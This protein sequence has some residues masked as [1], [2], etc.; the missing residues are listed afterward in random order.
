MGGHRRWPRVRA[1]AAL[2][3]TRTRPPMRVACHAGQL[4]QPV[5]GRHRPLRARPARPAR[6]EPASSRSRSRPA[7]RPRNVP[8]AVPWIDLGSPAR[9]RPLRAVAPAPAPGRAARR[10]RRARAEPG[11]PARTR[12]A[13]RGHGARHRVPPR[14]RGHD[15]PRRGVPPARPRARAPRSRPRARAVGVHARRADPRR[16]RARR[17]R[18][19]AARRRTAP[20]RA[21]RD[22]IDAT[23]ARCGVA[24]A[25]PAD[26]R[27][28]RA[29]QGP[30]DD[31]RRA[32][33]APHAPHPTSSSSSSARRAGATSPASTGRACACSARCRGASSTRSTGAR[34]ACCIAS[35]Y[36]GFGLPALEALARGAP[37]VAADDSAL[38]EVVGDAG[39]LFPPGDVDALRRRT[40][41]RRSTTTRSAPQLAATRS[42]AAPERSPGKL[43]RRARRRL[44]AG[45]SARHRGSG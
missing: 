43:G 30:A 34:R 4:L 13:A 39:L 37:L 25:V 3:A 31:R 28:R 11:G 16:V 15:A 6:R 23:V 26:G 35:R 18:R 44:P 9:Q 19:R 33:A 32:A 27:H 7:P 38:A 40:R 8:G 1:T 42:D 2:A 29:P 12:R 5:P 45:R 24:R 14:P 21:I 20:C 17:R 41:T 36:E 22:E 10:R